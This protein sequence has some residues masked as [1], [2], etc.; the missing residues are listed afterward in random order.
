MSINEKI[1]IKNIDKKKI[2]FQNL[3]KT[4]EKSFYSDF[5]K[6]LF[7]VVKIEIL[8]EDLEL[9]NGLTNCKECKFFTTC[10]KT[11][12]HCIKLETI[13]T[14]YRM[15][16]ELDDV[17]DIMW[18]SKDKQVKNYFELENSHLNN[19]INF[20]YKNE[21]ATIE[22][23]AK[24]QKIFGERLMLQLN[25]IQVEK[26][27]IRERMKIRVIRKIMEIKEKFDNNKIDTLEKQ[28]EFAYNYFIAERS[29][30]PDNR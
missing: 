25:K 24:K 26:N 11:N 19:L 5:C 4:Y 2:E 29:D 10:N 22:Q 17:E 21:M 23:L 16:N 8:K 1:N 14:D 28:Q 12:S 27:K 13:Y 6:I 15:C 20:L 3:I 9:F 7:K 30:Y 18:K